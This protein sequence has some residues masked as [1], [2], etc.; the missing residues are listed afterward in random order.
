MVNILIFH[1][2]IY[3]YKFKL[4][5]N[6][7]YDIFLLFYNI[8]RIDA[9]EERFGLGRL[10]NDS[11]KFANCKMVKIISSEGPHLCLYAQRDILPDE[12]ILY[13]YGMKNQPWYPEVNII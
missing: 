3:T 8:C 4:Q 11:Y 2:C 5:L 6:Y 12:E 13:F 1:K 9:S 7:C 10:V